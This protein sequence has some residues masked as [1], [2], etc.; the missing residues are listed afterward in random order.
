MQPIIYDVAVSADGFICG[1]NAD[2]SRFPHEGPVLDDYRARLATYGTALMGRETYV[3]GYA[4]GLTAGANPY[5]HM[6]SI[7]ISKTLDLPEDAQVEQIPDLT[8]IP[9]LK[10]QASRPLYLC[11]GGHL[12][13]TLLRAGFIDQVVLKRAPILLGTGVLLW[14]P[15][16]PAPEARLIDHHDYGGGL[17]LQRYH[18]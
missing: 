15:G 6:R 10:A 18:L 13:C 17:T 3:F 9:H 8:T 16:A 2:I 11:G 14:G 1:A 4:Y 12:A 7:V 5:P